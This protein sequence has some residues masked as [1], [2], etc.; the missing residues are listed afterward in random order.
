MQ[1]NN[2][3]PIQQIEGDFNHFLQIVNNKRI[4]FSGRFG[5]GKTFFLKEFFAL[6]KDTYEV[7]HLFPT[8]YQISNN[9]DIVELLKYDLL[10]E[11]LKKNPDVFNEN[12]VKG[13]K[14]SALLFFTWFKNKYSVNDVIRS[15][16]QVGE[17]ASG[18]FP[19]TSLDLFGKL[20]RPLKDLLKL[21]KEF[22]DFK[23]EYIAGEK[24][25][26]DKYLE[27]LK[28]K[29]ISET[30]Y[31]SHLISEKVTELKSEKKSI[32]ILD[33]M[34]RIDPEHIFRILNVFSAHFNDE[35]N[36][37][38]FDTIIIVGD[39]KNIKSIFHHKYG[40][41]A[42]FEGYFDKFF[43]LKPYFLDNH[44]IVAESLPH[45]IKLIKHEEPQL[46]SAIGESGYIK[47]L[48]EDVLN[49]SLNLGKL[50]LRQ[51]FKPI[52]YNFSE[53]KAGVYSQDNFRDNFQQIVDIG[54]KLL[55]A[56]FGGSKDQFV[57]ILKEIR[58]DIEESDNGRAVPYKDYAV[59]IIK[60]VIDIKPGTRTA[61][62]NYFITLSSDHNS[63]HLEIE[64]AASNKTKIF[65]DLLIE[66]VNKSKYK[67]NSH[68][69]YDM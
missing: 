1:N 66:Y 34:D 57:E 33:D 38:R 25:L 44:R 21:D 55:I 15:T 17:D 65:Y 32:L 61:Y 8:N 37:F 18:M 43:S 7:F 59:S 64:G 69:E 45:L 27:I 31:L 2:I 20:G 16:I 54:I 13:V 9:E 11:L 62:K 22:Q 35:N 53:L 48:L 3:I 23:K 56:I 60:K 51:L 26:V 19:I 50:N 36:K 29:N 14:D 39:V 58:N 41:E 24:G 49:R 28:S 52:N 30:D 63:R 68:F 46:K 47:L 67:K 6:K 4:F 12:Q 40:K 10:V 5:I 42:D